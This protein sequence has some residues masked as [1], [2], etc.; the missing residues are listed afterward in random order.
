[1][2]GISSLAST[3][4]RRVGLAR[5]RV[6]SLGVSGPNAVRKT[7]WRFTAGESSLVV[8]THVHP[9]HESLPETEALAQALA[10]QMGCPLAPSSTDPLVA[11]A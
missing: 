7:E 3:V 11:L 10:E 8:R 9:D 2:P 4:A 1:M 5:A 6:R